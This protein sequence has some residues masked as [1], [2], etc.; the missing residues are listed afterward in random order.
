MKRVQ[1][2]ARRAVH[3]V[4]AGYHFDDQ[5]PQRSSFLFVFNS[6]VPPGLSGTPFPTLSNS[7]EFTLAILSPSMVN[8]TIE[9]SLAELLSHGV[10]RSVSASSTTLVVDLPASAQNQALFPW[11]LRVFKEHTG[12]SSHPLMSQPRGIPNPLG[13]SEDQRSDVI[14]KL[15]AL[16]E[17]GGTAGVRS[18]QFEI[19]KHPATA[20]ILSTIYHR[21]FPREFFVDAEQHLEDRCLGFSDFL[22]N[23]VRVT[24]DMS[25]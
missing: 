22:E 2:Q 9:Q 11:S 6:R 1:A 8:F 5:R 23:K 15:R 19:G 17:S 13:L 7:P 10:F 20:A 4:P 25:G 3:I 18:A 12:I 21:L 16:R 24:L 14:S